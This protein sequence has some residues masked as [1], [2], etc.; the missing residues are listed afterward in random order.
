MLDTAGIWETLFSL[1][2]K[3]WGIL[4]F[5]EFGERTEVLLGLGLLLPPKDLQGGRSVTVFSHEYYSGKFG[6]ETISELF[7]LL[8]IWFSAINGSEITILLSPASHT[9]INGYTHEYHD[10][11]RSEVLAS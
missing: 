1:Q 2:L 3:P 8:S 6:G 7:V 5:L 4:D 11:R 9:T 10:D